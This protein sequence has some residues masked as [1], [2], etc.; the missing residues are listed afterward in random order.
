MR[1]LVTGGTGF[2]GRHLVKKLE[3]PRVLGRDPKRI[4]KLLRNVDAFQWS[5]SSPPDAKVFEDIDTVFHLAGESVFKGRWTEEKK[6]R[7]MRSR[8]E[9]T[10]NLV[11]LLS[12]LAKPPSTLICASAIGYYGPQGEKILTESSPA[13]DD[14][15]SRV[16]IAWEAE[17]SKAEKLGIRVVQLRT[18]IVLGGDGGALPQ[19]L[20]PFRLGVGGRIGSG[21][22]YM[23]WIHIDDLVNIMLFAAGT[24][25]IRGPVNGVAPSPMTNREFTATLASVLHR[26]AMLQVPG[27]VLKITLGEFADVLLGSQRVIPE[28]AAEA[29]YVFRYP[30]LNEALQ[31]LVA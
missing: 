21:N 2:I 9:G 16:C 13:G 7:I 31:D 10:R 14:F 26:P 11:E 6:E 22:Q 15:L 29:G 3:Q 8:V 28:K 1:S 23:S 5:P 18:G 30:E 20:T 17:A 24:E 12:T 19:M 4:H 25:S 27:F